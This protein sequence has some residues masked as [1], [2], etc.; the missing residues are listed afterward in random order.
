MLKVSSLFG[1]SNHSLEFSLRLS[2]MLLI[3]Y[4]LN[5]PFNE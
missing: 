5:N 4:V 2:N 3:G 1:F